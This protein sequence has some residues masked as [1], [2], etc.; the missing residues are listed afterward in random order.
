MLTTTLFLFLYIFGG[1]GIVVWAGIAY[2]QKR[3]YG[4]NSPLKVAQTFQISAWQYFTRPD[5]IGFILCQLGLFAMLIFMFI[6]L[7]MEADMVWGYFVIFASIF[8]FF[9][10]LGI[11]WLG[12]QLH[13]WKYTKIMK[14]VTIP[15]EKELLISDGESELRLKK[16][17][18]KELY[19]VGK[20]NPRDV[21]FLYYVYYLQNGSSFV[22]TFAMPGRWVLEDYLGYI[23]PQ[24]IEDPKPRI[25]HLPLVSVVAA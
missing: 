5:F 11:E 9:G 7:P 1:T 13:F 19:G 14:I 18:I 20:I 2:S 3:W 12:T 24:L 21:S 15:E 8:G 6:K 4:K 10:Y 16:G 25:S 23:E 17:D 22:L